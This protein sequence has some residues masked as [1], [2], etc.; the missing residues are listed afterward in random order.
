[1]RLFGEYLLKGFDYKNRNIR[2]KFMGDRT[3]LD[4][5]LQ[6]LMNKLEADSSVKTGM[7]L[8]IAINYGGRPEIVRAAQ[9]LAAPAADTV[10]CLLCVALA[11]T[12]F[13]RWEKA[14]MLSPS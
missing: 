13:R 1:M 4:E 12:E 11:R 7:T 8:N 10:T 9:Q 2:I 5:K 3:V 6:Q 14:G